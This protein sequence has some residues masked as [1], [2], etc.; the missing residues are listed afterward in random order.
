V[1]EAARAAREA[2]VAQAEEWAD[3]GVVVRAVV[4]RLRTLAACGMPEGVAAALEVAVPAAEA[5]VAD[6]DP[7]EV[8]LGPGQAQAQVV[9]SVAAPAVALAALVEALEAGE[10][11]AVRA[12]A[13]GAAEEQVLAAAQAAEE[14][15]VRPEAE[16]PAVVAPVRAEAA[17]LEDQGA[18]AG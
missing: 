6:L 16:G 5:S 4:A 1:V 15:L 2:A 11:S 18:V 13:Q 12:V 14:D 7:V 10:V 17:V 3:R 9:E 8:G